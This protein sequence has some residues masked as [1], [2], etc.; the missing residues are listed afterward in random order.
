[1]SLQ[2]GKEATI[3]STND[4]GT[5]DYLNKEEKIEYLPHSIHKIYY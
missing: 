2:I 3:S 4:V 5:T 1:M